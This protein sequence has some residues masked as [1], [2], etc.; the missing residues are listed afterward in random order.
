MYRKKILGVLLLAA[1]ILTACGQ[2]QVA[3]K[4]E[5]QV[6]ENISGEDTAQSE[7]KTKLE[8]DTKEEAADNLKEKFGEN[9]I[10]DQTFE[11]ELSEY[12]GKVYF[13]STA[14]NQDTQK[15]GMQIVQDGRV[16]T[17]VE[18]YIPEQLQDKKFT[19]LDA[20]SFYDVNYDNNTDIVTIVT[21]EDTTFAAIY[22]GTRAEFEGEESNFYIQE[23]LSE[24]ISSRLEQLS[25]PE[26]RN[27][28]SNGK[29]NGSFENYKE[30]YLAVSQLCELENGEN[31]YNLIYFNE[32]DIPEFVAGKNGYY[33]SLY[34]YDNGTVYTLMD[35]WVYGAMGNAG[36]EYVAKKNSLRNYNTDYAGAILYTTYMKMSPMHALDTVV[37]IKTYNFDDVNKNGMPDEEEA[38][39]IGNYS[40]SYIGDNEVTQEEGASYDMGEYEY[41][42]GTMSLETLKNELE[43]Q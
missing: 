8:S 2:E 10:A 27:L 17:Q 4:Q 43:D 34:T 29:K 35:H 21:Y 20:V 19:S 33:T 9:C 28:L 36:Y 40:V 42:E 30:A 32:D 11:V 31:T 14:P 16:L 24:N 41:I 23:Q 1:G 15:F 22:Y 37:E 3:N 39:S 6:Y 12:E 5:T 18:A 38:D 26:I 25:I 13:V 7:E